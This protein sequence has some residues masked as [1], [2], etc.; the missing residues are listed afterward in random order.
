MSDDVMGLASEF[1]SA[2]RAEWDAAVEKVLRGRSFERVLVSR[3]RDGLDI[4]PLYTAEDGTT[5]AVTGAID[6][7]RLN[8]GWDVRQQHRL[9]DPA[10]TNRAIITDLERGVTSIEVIAEGAETDQLAEALAG[11]LFDTAAVVLAP[12]A[13]LDLAR[14]LT[15]LIVERGDSETTGSWLGLDPLGAAA[16]AGTT[17]DGVAVAALAHDLAPRLPNACTMTVDSVRYVEAGATP[18]QELGWALATGVAYLRLLESAG[19]SVAQ[20]AST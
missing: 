12:H 20:A 17:V 11:V 9:L 5:G 2:E 7:D 1:E 6:P 18:A 16:R 3:T 10:D 13:D 15:G 19:L 14:V 8:Y 4:Q